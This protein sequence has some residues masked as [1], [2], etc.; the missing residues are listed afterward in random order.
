MM[1]KYILV[2]SNL[3]CSFK[4]FLEFG[5]RI[6]CKYDSNFMFVRDS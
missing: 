4:Y 5:N 3:C 2:N 1:N 6:L